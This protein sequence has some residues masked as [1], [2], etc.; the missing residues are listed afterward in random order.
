MV[1]EMFVKYVAPEMEV[2]EVEVEKGFASSGSNADDFT[3]G[4]TPGT[5]D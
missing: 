1:K 5:E 4:Q 2:V 3:G